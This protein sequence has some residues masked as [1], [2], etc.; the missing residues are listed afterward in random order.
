M[1]WW[2]PGA[3]GEGGKRRK[4]KGRPWTC[5]RCGRAFRGGGNGARASHTRKCP[6]RK[7]E[8]SKTG[9]FRDRDS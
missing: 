6:G 9:G 2:L 7:P 8:A 3:P 1:S 5:H 4:S